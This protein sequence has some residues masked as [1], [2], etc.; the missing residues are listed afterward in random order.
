[1]RS[2][3]PLEFE[4]ARVISTGAPA[5][6]PAIGRTI[7]VEALPPA[8]IAAHRARQ[9]NVADPGRHRRSRIGGRGLR[10]VPADGPI[11]YWK[12]YVG[13]GQMGG[14]GNFSDVR[15]GLTITQLRPR[16]LLGADTPVR[17]VTGTGGASAVSCWSS[18][19]A[20]S[21]TRASSFFSASPSIQP[22]VFAC[23]VPAIRPSCSANASTRCSSPSILG[24]P[25]E[26]IGAV[27]VSTW[28]A[29]GLRLV[30]CPPSVSESMS[31]R[32]FRIR[33]LIRVG[34][35]CGHRCREATNIACVAP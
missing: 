4:V 23:T 27:L 12:R 26:V 8:V 30:I 3:V 15:I 35:R 16:T 29:L 28:V 7:D 24:V 22:A 10:G 25:G 6:A 21:R 31:A 32:R 13:V 9:V 14:H 17:V 18:S 11:S 2:G 34:I 1:M 5:V 19:A 33:P 20:P